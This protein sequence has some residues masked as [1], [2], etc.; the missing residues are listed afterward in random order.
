MTLKE[1]APS[2]DSERLPG[3]AE[4]FAH[5]QSYTLLSSAKIQTAQVTPNNAGG[6]ELGGEGE[7]IFHLAL[8]EAFVL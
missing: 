8:A 1:R 3:V 2:T 4:A 6:N 5:T 7:S